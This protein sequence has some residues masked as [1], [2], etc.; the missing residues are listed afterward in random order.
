MKLLFYGESPLNPTG[1]G[2]VNKHLLAAFSKVAEVTAVASTHYVESYDRA[3]YPYEII[4]CEIVPVPERDATHQKNYPNIIA[5]TDALDWDVWC[6]QADMGWH[7]ELLIRVGKILSEHPEKQAIFYMPVDGDVSYEFA[8]NIF[9]LCTAPVVYTHHA[10][11]VIER[12]APNIAKNVSVMWL[13]TEPDVFYPLPEE[14]RKA[15]RLKLFGEAY[16]DQFLCINV[17]RNQMRK[18]LARCMG[19]FHLFHVKHPD[20]SLYMHSVQVDAGGSLPTQALIVGCDIFKRPAEIVFSSLD[21]AN[22]WSR[23]SLNEVYN[24]ADCLVST[25]HGEGWGLTTTEAMAAGVPVVVPYNTAN[26][27]ILGEAQERGFGI[28]TGGDLDHTVFIYP[29]GGGPVASIHA[30]SF[31]Q[32]LECVYYNREWA[33]EKA[34][35]ARAWCLENTWERREAEWQQLL[36]LM[37]KSDELQPT[38]AS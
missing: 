31:V 22:P 10:K 30:E 23:E 36:R 28:R 37:Q 4:G 15:A 18:D 8:F 32:Q 35:L 38:T 6:I 9:R 13:G 34:Q 12:Y 3:E 7:N 21:L 11:S 25:A 2:Q 24:A 29:N 19:A 27:D 5:R 26:I 1:F 20:S 33:Q 16:R 14:E 17:N